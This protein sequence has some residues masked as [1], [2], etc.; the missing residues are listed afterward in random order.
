MAIPEAAMRELAEVGRDLYQLGMV[1]SRGGNLSIRDGHALWITGT[2]TALGHLQPL[3]VSRVFPDGQH[4]PPPPSSDTIL[5]WT[6]YATTQAGA[7][8][9]AH[10]HHAIA[11]SYDRDVFTPEDLEGQMHIPA[12]PCRSSSRARARPLQE[13]KIADALRE[14]RAALLG[15]SCRGTGPTRAAAPS[16]TRSTGSR[17]WRRRRLLRTSAAS[18]PERR[19][20]NCANVVDAMETW[21]LNDDGEGPIVYEPIAAGRCPSPSPPCSPPASRSRT[22][23]S[24]SPHRRGSARRRGRRGCTRRRSRR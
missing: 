10:P 1:S 17:R 2:G 14:S 23:S 16:A 24:P 18:P 5:H 19:S 4:E 9:H 8:A 7:I 15:S 3:D 11:L 21:L 20:T 6:I 12:V 13:Q 22:A